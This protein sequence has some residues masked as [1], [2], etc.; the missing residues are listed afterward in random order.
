MVQ[1]KKILLASLVG[2][3]GF[4]LALAGFSLIQ[5]SQTLI[6]FIGILYLLMAV[7][8]YFFL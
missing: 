8:I 2:I 5:L 7:L 4:L 3:G 1:I 6:L